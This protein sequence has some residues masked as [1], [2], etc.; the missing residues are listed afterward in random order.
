MRI[1]KLNN[2]KTTVTTADNFVNHHHSLIRPK[3]L[4]AHT[5]D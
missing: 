4:T 1:C 2:D 5:P 3:Y